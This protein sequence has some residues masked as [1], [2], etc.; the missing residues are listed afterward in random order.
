MINPRLKFAISHYDRYV[1]ILEG[2]VRAEG[3]ELE[4]LHVGQSEDRRHGRDRHERMIR[5]GEFDAAELSLSSYLMARARKLPFTAIPVFPR[6]LFSQSQIW[7]NSDRSVRFPQD[8]IGKRIGLNTFQTTLSVLAKGDLQNEYGVPWR[9]ITWVVSKE[10][11]VPFAPPDG[12]VLE[13]A[14]NNASLG[15]LLQEG[16][17]DAIFRPH[18][19]RE[20][21]EGA[22]NIKRL[23][24]DPKAEEARY[25]HKYG[26]YPIMHV[27]AFQDRV[28]LEHPD[29]PM[30]FLNMF[31]RSNAITSHYYDDP[32]WSRLAWGRLHL[33]EERRLL[34][35]DIWPNG[36]AKNRAN[37]ELFMGHSLDQGL[38]SEIMP[39]ESLFATGTLAT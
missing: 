37:L 30:A 15:R 36:V 25:Y 1:P 7:I 22:A 13:T 11:T 27:V 35:D 14:P 16:E 10:E 34:G 23:F 21:L 28:L 4:L 24:A 2:V 5:G 39:V 38:I 19:P 8:L 17:I 32:N 6:R 33:E 26:F 3:F 29:A 18:P 20:A 9:E 12:L 31:E